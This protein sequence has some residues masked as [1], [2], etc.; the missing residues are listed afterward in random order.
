[1]RSAAYAFNRGVETVALIPVR[2]G[3]GELEQL[4]ARGE[5][6]P[7][8]L[9]QLEAALDHA[10]PLA[11]ER[12]VVTAD[13]WDAERL[14]C[15]SACGPARLARLRRINLSGRSEPPIDCAACGSR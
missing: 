2:G 13:L 6:T 3:N 11:G 8:T 5:F 7:P 1:M 10:L 4:A 9:A 12:G 15:C 14:V